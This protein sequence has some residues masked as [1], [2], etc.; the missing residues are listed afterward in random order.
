MRTADPGTDTPPQPLIIETR[1]PECG[2]PGE[3]G[4]W[5]YS[6]YCGFCG[7]LLVFGGSLEDELFVVT[8]ASP[9]GD[10]LIGLLVATEVGAYRAKLE[11]RARDPESLGLHELPLW[12]ERRVEAF[13]D[14]VRQE[15]EL[16]HRVDFFA[17]YR[18]V[19]KT[20]IQGVLGRRKNGP[21]ESFIQSFYTEQLERLYDAGAF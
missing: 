12:I 1:C 7:S 11:A 10:D 17:P 20:V 19:E 15:L 5:D 9:G 4:L 8:T 21:K 16:Q 18:I 6:G 3:A 14:R 2:A 13:A